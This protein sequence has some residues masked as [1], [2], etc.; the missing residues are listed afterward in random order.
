[1]LETEDNNI[2]GIEGY[3]SCYLADY[4]KKITAKI[5]PETVKVYFEEGEK[6]QGVLEAS[7]ENVKIWL[8]PRID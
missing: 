6:N 4:L 5:S 8:A 7:R 3:R 2:G 1:M